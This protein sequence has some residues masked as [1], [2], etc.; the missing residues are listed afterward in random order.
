[1]ASIARVKREHLNMMAR[2][3]NCTTTPQEFMVLYLRTNLSREK[4]AESLR[5]TEARVVE[6]ETKALEKLEGFT[7]LVQDVVGG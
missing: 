7:E 3:M 2:A 6:I 5:A 4:V 1:M